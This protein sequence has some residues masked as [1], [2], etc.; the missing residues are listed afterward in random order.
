MSGKTS[1][2]CARCGD[3]GKVRTEEDHLD[4]QGN[5]VGHTSGTLQCE[6]RRDLPPRDGKAS[7]WG[8]EQTH[9]EI[10]QSSIWED[11][12]VEVSVCA[13]VPYD[14]NGYRVHRRG[15]RYYPTTATLACSES[16][17]FL[18]PDDLRGLAA[19]LTRAADAIDAVDEPDT[20][21][22]GHW[23]PCECGAETPQVK[24]GESG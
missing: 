20:D 14:E 18:G 8:S 5:V 17:S 16:I 24:E 10:W 11:E 13:E 19:V 2:E 6:C 4:Q 3:S 9:E 21:P 22:C 1:I 7:W 12:M 15:N 23:H